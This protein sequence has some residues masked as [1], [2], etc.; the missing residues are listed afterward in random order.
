L[1]SLSLTSPSGEQLES[2]H[3]ER[4]RAQAAHDLI[5]YYNQFSRGDTSR[6]DALNK[7]GREGR[8]QVA[9]ILRRLTTVAREVDL[10]SADKVLAWHHLL[11]S[12][13]RTETQTRET[14]DKYCEKFEKDMLS[15]FDRCYRKGDPKLMHVCLCLR[16]VVTYLR[17]G[18]ALRPNIIRF[19]WGRILRSN[20]CES[21]RLFLE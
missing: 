11:V 2:V 16:Y 4:Q 12:N 20:L 6:L 15:L 17:F 9:V 8:S 3:I 7:E 19:Q 5:N 10:P 18:S 13:N 1:L 21:T 14:I